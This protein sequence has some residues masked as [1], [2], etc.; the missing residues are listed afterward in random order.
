MLKK[1]AAEKQRYRFG[2]NRLLGALFLPAVPI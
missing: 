1:I 2:E